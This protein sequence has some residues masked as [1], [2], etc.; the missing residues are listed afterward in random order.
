MQIFPICI[1]KT[2]RALKLTTGYGRTSLYIKI[3][4]TRL[5]HTLHSS[6]KKKCD[7]PQK[8]RY[9][10]SDVSINCV[11]FCRSTKSINRTFLYVF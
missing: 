3:D 9:Y 2:D 4:E 11:T 7:F 5:F 10:W 1:D 8:D 6:E